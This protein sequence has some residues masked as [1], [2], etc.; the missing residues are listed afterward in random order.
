MFIVQM[1]TLRHRE[2]ESL[3][4]FV[5]HFN[6]YQ[7]SRIVPKVYCITLETLSS[8]YLLISVPWGHFFEL[9]H[10]ISQPSPQFGAALRAVD[11]NERLISMRMGPGDSELLDIRLGHLKVMF[12]LG[13]ESCM[14]EGKQRR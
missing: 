13:S 3:S 5:Q 9:S 11:A 7:I 2:V 1:R 8:V 4:K 12:L 14:S 6:L 10:S